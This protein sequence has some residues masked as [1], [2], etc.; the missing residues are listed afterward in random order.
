MLDIVVGDVEVEWR[1]FF[2][3]DRHGRGSGPRANGEEPRKIGLNAEPELSA[4]LLLPNHFVGDFGF[5]CV[6]CPDKCVKMEI[7]LL[8]CSTH[9]LS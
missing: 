7:T 1:L 8:S 5:W 4:T 6:F 2:F 3:A 9:V